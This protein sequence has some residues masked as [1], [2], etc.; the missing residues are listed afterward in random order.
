MECF[1]PGQQPAWFNVKHS[2]LSQWHLVL[3]G[4]HLQWTATCPGWH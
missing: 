1:L 3:I 2:V 4:F